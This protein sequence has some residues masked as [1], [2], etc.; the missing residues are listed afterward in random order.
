[1]LSIRN[2]TKK[3][4]NKVVIDN[5]SLTV[6]HGQIAFLLG[7][8]GVGKSTLLRILNNLEAADEG[9]VLLDESPLNLSQVNKDHTIGM[10][11]QQFN[12]FP[13]LTILN[14][15]TLAL[16]KTQNMPK[17]KAEE[18]AL[19]L[20]K[21]YDLSNKAHM[22]PSQLSGGQKQRI[23]LARMLALEPKIICLDEPTSALD[24][25]LTTHVATVITELA[26]KGLIVLVATHDVTLLEKLNCTIHL[27]K[28]GK[29]VESATSTDYA[30]N[31]N[32]YPKIH[33]FITGALNT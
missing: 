4:D 30:K 16:I 7:P 1:M 23:A 26:K 14:N 3:F 2:I 9:T 28:N 5:I 12:L 19:L 33:T 20:L 24:P 25:L 31:K 22:Y 27:M 10:V 32:D 15:I 21:Q 6:D 29:I 8:S 18:K 13:H 17:E 11:F